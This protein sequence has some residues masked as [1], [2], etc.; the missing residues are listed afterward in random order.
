[1]NNYQILGLSYGASKEEVKKAFRKLA[2]IHHPDKG[3]DPEKFKAI[4]RAYQELM[5]AP[6]PIPFTAKPNGFNPNGT[7]FTNE[8]WQ[9]VHRAQDIFRSQQMA[10]DAV[11]KAYNDLQNIMHQQQKE[12][13]ERMK[14]MWEDLHR[15]TGI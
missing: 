4:N 10:Q 9:N 14:R 8:F 15:Q 7:N 13:D 12:R 5:K 1:M 6:D 11:N 2:H 3:G